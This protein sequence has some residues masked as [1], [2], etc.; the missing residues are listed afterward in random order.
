MFI[1]IAY[2]SGDVMMYRWD[3]DKKPTIGEKGFKLALNIYRDFVQ[4]LFCKILR[5][6]AIKP[7]TTGAVM[8][9]SLC[10]PISFLCSKD[11]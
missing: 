11:F 5:D 3:V 8:F 1:A 9:A 2:V 7:R 4:D 10:L 6:G